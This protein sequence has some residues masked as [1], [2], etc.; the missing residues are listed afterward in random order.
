VSS[1]P[2]W[3]TVLLILAGCATHRADHFYTLSTQPAQPGA[4][5][6]AFAR[7]VSLH[8]TLPA[9]LDRSELILT[10]RDQVTILEHERWASPL[11]DQFTG[12]L[13]QD[14]E[15]R[16]PDLVIASRNLEQTGLPA[17]R[18]S[19]EVVRVTAERGAQVTLEI[20]WRVLDA[21]SGNVVVGRDMF[22]AS[23]RSD[24]YA[25]VAAALSQCLAQLAD[26]L[27]TLLPA[28]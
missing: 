18:I 6:A 9:S 15:A 28:T 2:Y 26:K 13:G 12:T 7:Q 8:M 27:I 5:R 1:K 23:M 25:Q 24:D 20:R 3:L 21:G 4:S 22:A 19:V 11:L 17:S 10:T 14:L 16:R